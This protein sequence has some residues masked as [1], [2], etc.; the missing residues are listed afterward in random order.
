MITSDNRP[1]TYVTITLPVNNCAANLRPRS[2]ASMRQ[3]QRTYDP[4]R[5]KAARQ[6]DRRSDRP[7]WDG[8]FPF[9][10]RLCGGRESRTSRRK[11]ARCPPGQALD[12]GERRPRSTYPTGGEMEA[13]KL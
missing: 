3:P 10:V 11:L 2:V 9:H 5:R 12:E 1:T 6:N 8:P 13:M 4:R 7:L